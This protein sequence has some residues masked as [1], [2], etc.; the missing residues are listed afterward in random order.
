MSASRTPHSAYL[1]S[2]RA[3]AQ[4][5]AHA[6]LRFL[7]S[8]FL[9]RQNPRK[10]AF[11]LCHFF[12]DVKKCLPHTQVGAEWDGFAV[13]MTVI[14]SF[15]VGHGVEFEAKQVLDEII[16][17]NALAWLTFLPS[18]FLG[19]QNPRKQAFFFCVIFFGTSKTGFRTLV[20]IHC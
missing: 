13:G 8:Q 3:P 11:C 7:P 4:L 5:K 16:I 20:F 14:E 18:Q 12:G 17:A 1:S 9:G 19:R 10:Q 15:W 6:L 2:I